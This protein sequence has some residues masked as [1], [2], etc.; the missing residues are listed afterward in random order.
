MKV[1]RVFIPKQ[2]GDKRPLGIPSMSDRIIQQAFKQVLEPA[3]ST[4]I[5]SFI[6]I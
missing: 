6:R 5:K 3:V 4:I 1:R 2:N